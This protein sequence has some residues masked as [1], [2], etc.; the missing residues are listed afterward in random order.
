[1]RELVGG[2]NTGRTAAVLKKPHKVTFNLFRA[3]DPVCMG[4]LW[5][6]IEHHCQASLG[7]VPY[8]SSCAIVRHAVYQRVYLT[9]FVTSV[10]VSECDPV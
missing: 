10:G 5:A 7:P 2:K 8:V 6:F 3:E 9:A 1:M 4:V